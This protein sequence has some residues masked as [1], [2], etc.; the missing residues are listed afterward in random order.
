LPQSSNHELGL[1][2]QILD[3]REAEIQ[4]EISLLDA[5]DDKSQG[6]LQHA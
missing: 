2:Q 1:M 5:A 4:N 3:W 6:G